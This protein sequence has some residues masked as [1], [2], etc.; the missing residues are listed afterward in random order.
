MTY[1]PPTLIKRRSRAAWVRYVVLL[2]AVAV[3]LGTCTATRFMGDSKK[4][5]TPAPEESATAPVVEAPTAPE[6]ENTAPAPAPEAP[7]PEAP[8][9]ATE[10]P[11]APVAGAPVAAAPAPP[12]VAA[13]GSGVDAR[14]ANRWYYVGAL[15]DGPGAIYSR[16][17]GQWDYAFACALPARTIEFIAV[18]TGNPGT[19]DQQSMSVG[20]TK[21]MMDG[22]YSKDG[23]GTIASKLPAKNAFFSAL[24]NGATLEV[25]LL[26]NRKVMLPIGPDVVRLIRACRG[27]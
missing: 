17:G 15:G 13:A 20:A 24:T 14:Q 10:A 6:T 2:L 22:T 25:Q 26:A 16:T 18:N 1:P 3:V 12:P 23:G 19:F 4:A 5:A 9:P 27:N 11:A 8:A 7:A 21:L